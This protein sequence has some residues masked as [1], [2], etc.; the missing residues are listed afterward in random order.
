MRVMQ[1]MAGAA[2]G[3]A[4][5]FFDRLTLALDRAGVDQ[6]IV[7]RRNAERAALLQ[8]AKRPP[9][10]F[11]F[12]GALDL[13]TGHRLR[14]AVRRFEPDI[15][16]SWMSRAT[17]FAPIG[18]HV[19]AARLGGYYR[20]ANFERCDHL[21]GNTRHIC[22]YLI[23]AGWPRARTSYLPNFVDAVAMPPVARRSLDTPDDA[24]LL[25]ALGRL[26]ANKGFDVLLQAV[27]QIPGAYLWLAGEG[28]K[29]AELAQQAARLGIADRVRF[30]G[31]R[32]DAPALF[33][34]CDVFI[35]PS[36]HEPLGNVVIEA[37]AQHR[38]V[39]AAE[40]S[41]PGALITDGV[42][43]LLAPV[44]DADALAAAVRR[45]LASPDLA[46]TLVTGGR[47]AYEAE[48]T[49]AKV[50]ARYMEFFE[51]IMV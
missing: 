5:A 9:L 27:A 30:L 13:V 22:D 38:P 20:L 4:E 31:W 18:R 10:E 23:E 39:V 17:R 16:L 51:S 35:C 49:E 44:E 26:H 41:G 25:F 48:F 7:I 29:Q 46:A 3:G 19:L 47:T 45:V 50:V 1:V 43:G 40:S 36:R 6:Q 2:H 8:P 32:T 15:L 14:R 37:W 24:P 33:A 34:A 21:V 12:G 42:S 11:A 28:P